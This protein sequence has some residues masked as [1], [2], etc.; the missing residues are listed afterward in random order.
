MIKPVNPEKS[1]KTPPSDV[2]DSLVDA[3]LAG[4]FEV[5]VPSSGFVH[6]VMESVRG[7]ASEPPPIAF[8]WSRAIPGAIA[9][10]CCLGALGV[11][12]MRSLHGGART[13]PASQTRILFAHFFRPALGPGEV[14][15]GLALLVSCLS[16]T[17]IAAS[18][19]LTGRSE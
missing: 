3:Q 19:R 16:I 4:D 8:P 14:M 10:L 2:T 15:I 9:I 17:A 1:D 12:A 18:F 11:V 13:A 6:A 5:L 7:H